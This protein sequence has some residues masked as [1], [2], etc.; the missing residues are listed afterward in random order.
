M[1]T[2]VQICTLGLTSHSK[3]IFHAQHSV[4][5][6]MK[7]VLGFG[8]M[9]KEARRGKENM[10]IRTLLYTGDGVES[11]LARWGAFEKGR[12]EARR[13]RREKG[14]GAGLGEGRPGRRMRK[15]REQVPVKFSYV[16]PSSSFCWT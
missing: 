10:D 4:M 13:D 8:A 11:A 16:F 12:R 3:N 14:Q 2:F 7:S 1:E 5:D 6:T 15:G 9:T